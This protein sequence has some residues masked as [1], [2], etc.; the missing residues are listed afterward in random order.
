MLGKAKRVRIEKENTTIIDGAGKKSDIEARIAQIKAQTEETTSDYDK[1]KLQ[2]RLAKFAGGVAIIRVGGSTEVEVKERSRRGRDARDQGRRRRRHRRGRRRRAVA[3]QGRSAWRRDASRP[4]C[5]VRSDRGLSNTACCADALALKGGAA[6][7]ASQRRHRKSSTQARTAAGSPSRTRILP[8]SNRCGFGF[9]S[10]CLARFRAHRG[11]GVR[12][13]RRVEVFAG[14]L[15]APFEAFVS[16]ATV[17]AA[18]QANGER[19]PNR[20][21][22]AMWRQR[23]VIGRPKEDG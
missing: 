11:D 9:N 2:E 18:V 16:A 21:G 4:V 15:F 1:E 19:E 17:H 8:N 10:G 5:R 3:R 7:R 20:C 12:E 23:V 13:F 22:A 6:F 14:A